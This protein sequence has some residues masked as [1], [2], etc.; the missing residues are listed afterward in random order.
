MTTVYITKWALTQGIIKAEAEISGNTAVT[1]DMGWRLYAHGE[2]KD[3]HLDI[4]AAHARVE[5]MRTAK[6]ASHGRAIKALRSM[7]IAAM[8]GK[9]GTP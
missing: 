3:Y 7:D 9:K 1:Q 6:I 8:V 2:G 4:T 5:V